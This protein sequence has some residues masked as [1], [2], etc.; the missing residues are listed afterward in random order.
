MRPGNFPT[1]RHWRGKS[2]MED[3]EAG[4]KALAETVRQYH[5]QSIAIPPLGS[6]LG[7]LDWAEVKPRIEAVMAHH[8]KAPKMTAGRAAL[9]E[10]MRRYEVVRHTHAWNER[11]RQFTPRQIA[12]AADVLIGKGWSAGDTVHRPRTPQRFYPVQRLQAHGKN[13]ESVSALNC[14]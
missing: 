12:L 1:K 2:R 14:S 8:R 6:G 5:I 10:L 11:K 4:L 9:V 7:G 3:I 13:P